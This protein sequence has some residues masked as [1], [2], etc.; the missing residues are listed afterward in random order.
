VSLAGEIARE[1]VHATVLGE[2]RA[3]GVATL[4]AAKGERL[5]RD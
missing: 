5:V 2:R 1:I 4:L 3:V